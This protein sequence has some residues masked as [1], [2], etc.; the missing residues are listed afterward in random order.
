M[1]LVLLSTKPCIYILKKS[2]NLCLFLLI[3]NQM[4]P[5]QNDEPVDE[6]IPD[7]PPGFQPQTNPVQ[8]LVNL[9]QQGLQANPGSSSLSQTSKPSIAFKSFKALQPP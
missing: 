7:V 8:M 3:R 6:Q 2:I 5:N 4:N 9:L 1:H